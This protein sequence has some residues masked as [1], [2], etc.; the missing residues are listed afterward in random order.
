MTYSEVDSRQKLIALL[1]LAY[2]GELAAAHAY[3]GHWRSVRNADQRTA[4]QN[5][6][7]DEWR[8]RNL[9]GEML[10][11][12][13]SGPSQRRESS[14]QHDWPD[15]GIPLSRDGLVGADVRRRA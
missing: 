14:R 12:L 4:I 15:A 7:A 3:R 11:S 6:E 2:S 13:E 8:H 1:Q 10:A 9:V 5:I